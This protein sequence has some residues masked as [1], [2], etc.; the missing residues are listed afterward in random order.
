MSTPNSGDAPIAFASISGTEIDE[1]FGSAR[2]WQV[3]EVQNDDF[4][5]IEMRKT[6]AKCHGSC[7]VGFGHILETLH[8]CVALFVQ[9]I[10]PGAAAYMIGQGKRVFEAEG[11]IEEILAQIAERGLLA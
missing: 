9:K 3:Y 2:Y 6:V 11:E 8:D 5:H 10:G 4:Q 7:E 1:H